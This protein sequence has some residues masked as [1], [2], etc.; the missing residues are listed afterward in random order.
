MKHILLFS[1]FLFS[2]LFGS[3]QNIHKSI[4]QLQS[5]EYSKYNF[6]TEQQWDELRAKKNEMAVKKISTVQSNCILNKRVFGWNPYWAGSAYNNYQWNLLSDLCHFSYEVDATTGNAISTH[7][8]STDAAVTAA[9]SNGTKIHLC[10][11]LFSNHA[12]F[13]TSSSAMNTFISNIISLLNSRGANGVNIDFEAVPS[14]QSANLTAFF[15]N[16]CN[17]VHAANPSY[18]VSVALPAVDWSTVYDIPNL[19]NYIDIFIIMGYDYYYSGSTTAGPSDPL[20]N[21]ETSYNYTLTKSIT[22]Y[23]NKG[24]PNGKLLLGLP[25]YGEEWPTTALTIPSSTTGSGSS[26]TFTVVKTNANGYYSNPKFDANSYSVYYAFNN[27]TDRQLFINSQYSME[28]RFDIVNEFGIGGIGIWAL[29]YDDGYLDYWNAIQNKFSNCT[30]VNCTDTIFDM[31]GP[32]RNYYSNENYTYTIAP[33]NATSVSLAFSSF[34]SEATNDYLKIYDG[35]STA[36]PLIGT[37]SGTASPGTINSS[38]SSLTLQWFSNAS[39]VSS[40]W[41]ATWNCTADN[42]PPTTQVSVPN[43]WVTQNFTAAFTD[44]DN[45][46]GSGIQKSFYSVSDNN[47]TEWRANDTRGFFNDNF[48]QASIHPDWKP[49]QGI[50]AI[51]SGVLEQSDENNGNTNIAAALTQNLSNRYLYH[52][53]GKIS[54]SGTN[55]RAGFHFF[56]DNDSLPNRGNSYFVWFRVDQ[57]QCQFYKVVNDVFTLENTVPMTVAAGT[58]Y[59]YKVIYDRINGKMEMYQNNNFL[60]SWTDPSPYANGSY[61]SFRSGNSNWQVDDFEVFRS[62]NSSVTVTVGAAST[63]DIRYQSPNPATPAGNIKSICYDNAGNL[64]AISSQ[65]VLVDWTPPSSVA[66]NDGTSSD[67]DT[68]Y[69]NTQLDANWTSS[70]DPNSGI[71]NYW[72]AIGISAGDTSVVGWT[73]NASNTSVT[74]TGL[75]LTYGQIYYFSVKAEDGAGLF[76]SITSSDGQLVLNP[77][78]VNELNNMETISIY[79]NPSSGQF[80]VYSLQ[81][82]VQI[83]VYNMLG[84]K[85]YSSIVNSKLE[86]V[87]LSAANGIYFLKLKSESGEKILK[88]IVE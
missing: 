88:L 59:D 21:F 8:W 15:Q 41:Y 64:S 58:F 61:V 1:S 28:K 51:N 10:A 11:T 38:G 30:V 13:L 33:A 23:L 7:G 52:W 19:K 44:A 60:G 71:A 39:T 24:V 43:N 27:G 20:Y 65:T 78:G 79:P 42:I 74:K 25:Y 54:G 86:T 75:S 55:R 83:Q 68:T 26:R 73:N 62:R 50:W 77:N 57:N 63:N 82:P 67:I 37:Y 12:T 85:I 6:T 84:E 47:G 22:Y 29:S 46:N 45:M 76:S 80:T 81:F 5:E 53:Q 4:H 18:E 9:K 87:N 70:S 49:Y 40:G 69:S 17:Q 14:A 56:C 35:P 3:A 66:V 48:N 32:N 36:S 72:Y 16:L 34:N 2:A 31:G